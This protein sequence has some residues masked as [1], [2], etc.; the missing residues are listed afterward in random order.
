MMYPFPNVYEF[1]RGFH[2]KFIGTLQLLPLAALTVT[3]YPDERNLDR[4][5]E[6][7]VLLEELARRVPH[8]L[9]FR[10][11]ENLAKSPR[12]SEPRIFRIITEGLRSDQ[13][14]RLFE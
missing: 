13:F 1:L 8:V 12:R 9:L 3:H 5:I 6:L 14:G 7:D 4:S 10:D 2:R 11:Y